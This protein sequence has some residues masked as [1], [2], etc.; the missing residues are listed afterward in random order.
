MKYPRRGQSLTNDNLP[1]ASLSLRFFCVAC[2]FCVK[3]G[4]IFSH[5]TPQRCV[6]TFG[7]RPQRGRLQKTDST[8]IFGVP[9]APKP[10]K[11][12]KSAQNSQNRHKYAENRQKR[13]VFACFFRAIASFFGARAPRGTAGRDLLVLR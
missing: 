5:R 3:K 9:C 2:A 10:Q 1:R 8:R 7:I 13:L 12:Q 6:P 4:T 11:P